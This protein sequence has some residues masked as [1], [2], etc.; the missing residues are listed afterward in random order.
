MIAIIKDID[1]D[2]VLRKVLSIHDAFNSEQIAEHEPLT[3]RWITHSVTLTKDG[4]MLEYELRGGS[5]YSIIVN[6][7]TGERHRF[8]VNQ[9]KSFSDVISMIGGAT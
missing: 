5:P 6:N 8:Q 9:I 4:V 2:E 1:I 7:M 3:V